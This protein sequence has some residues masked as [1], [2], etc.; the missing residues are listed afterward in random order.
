MIMV[1]C[2]SG[3]L[4]VLERIEGTV[5][6][7]QCDKVPD[8]RFYYFYDSDLGDSLDFVLCMRKRP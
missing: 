1:N 3:S 5:D 8:Y 6:V 7:H 2:G 4:E